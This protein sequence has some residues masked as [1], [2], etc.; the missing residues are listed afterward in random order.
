MTFSVKGVLDR[1]RPLR[2][3]LILTVVS[4]WLSAC[5]VTP[6]YQKPVVT[7]PEKWSP[8]SAN[9]AHD[10]QAGREWWSHFGNSELDSL[11]SQALAR[12]HDLKAAM[13]RVAQARAQVRVAGAGLRPSLGASVSATRSHNSGAGSDGKT[14][15]EGL[16]SASYELDLWGANQASLSAAEASAEK[17]VYDQAALALV[18]EA[19]VASDYF[20]VLA[21]KDR[22]GVARRNLAA[23]ED[24]LKLVRAEYAQGATSALEVAQQE[25]TVYNDQAKIPQLMAQKVNLEHAIAVL[26]GVPPQGFSVTSGGLDAV[27]L[28][29]IGAGQPSTLLERRPDIRSAEA[30]LRGANAD[31]GIA[32]A[33]FLPTLDLSAN[34]GLAGVITGGAS[35]VASLVA[36]MTAP[37]YKGG[38]LRGQLAVSKA[39]LAE[40]VESY[41]QAV[42]AALQDVEDAR[43]SIY[44]GHRQVALLKRAAVS[45]RQAYHLARVR[46]KAGSVDFL[47]VLSA[48]QAQLSADDALLQAQASQFV[49]AAG[50]F[51]ALGGGWD[52]RE[53]KAGKG[54]S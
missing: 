33:A 45:A 54:N 43:S 27:S 21:L 31:V 37:L 46:F 9:V 3:M 23:A 49:N 48:E 15:Y 40:L 10:V 52:I 38:E 28:P 20:Q 29:K 25:T 42:L 7:L 1:H 26:I 8:E 2:H 39:K 17:S 36:Q 18:V 14:S 34:A 53:G 16:L 12:N 11:V 30:A 22:I 6:T 19:E 44:Y 51:K 24:L 32:R 47:S 35:T 13:Q 4:T 41:Q 5:S 50:L